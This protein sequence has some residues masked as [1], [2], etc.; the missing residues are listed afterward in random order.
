MP[1]PVRLFVFG[2]GY[3]AGAFA[4][5]MVRQAEWVGGTVRSADKAAGQGIAA[6]VWDG[7]APAADVLAALPGATHLLVSVPP[8]DSDPVLA[9]FGAAIRA[10]P[11]LAWIGTLSTVGVYGDY[12]GAWV[13]EATTPHPKSE[14]AHQRLAAEKAWGS[15][16]AEHGVPLAIF[17]LA[18]IYGPGRNALANLAEGRARR[19]VKPGQVFNR[20]HVDDIVQTLGAAVAR[21]AAGL[22]NLAD[23][24][25]A[26]PQDV[27]AY[28]AAL[29]GVAPPPEVPFAEADLTPMARSFYG[30]N[31]R[32]ANARIKRELGVSLLFPTYREGLSALWRDGTW[33]RAGPAG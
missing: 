10:A 7:S 16:A 25:P 13:S 6:T 14:R 32:V 11:R 29:M 27:V 15:L 4:R 20:I 33:R 17:R 31:K 9:H 23:D 2:L 28:A 26:P 12:G 8:G 1:D 30:D 24:E 3:S 5:A 21:S 18:G 19:I 22:F